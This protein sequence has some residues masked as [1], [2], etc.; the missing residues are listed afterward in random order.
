MTTAIK[1][2]KGDQVVDGRAFDLESCVVK[3]VGDGSNRYHVIASFDAE[4]RDGETIDQ[5]GWVLNYFTEHPVLVDSHDY[6]RVMNQI[7]EFKD[8]DI[9]TRSLE[10]VAE[11]YAGHG[12]QAADWAA[13]LASKGRA[14]YSVG[15]IPLDSEPRKGGGRHYTKQELLE[16]SQVIVPSS[17]Q[18]L[19]N[20]AKG[21]GLQAKLARELLSDFDFE[22]RRPKA[23]GG[24]SVPQQKWQSA[25]MG[26][27]SD[28][29][30]VDCH[31]IVAGCDDASQIQIPICSEHLRYLMASPAE[32]PGSPPDDDDVRM[33]MLTRGVQRLKA[34]R[35]ISASNMGKLH[36][37]MQA[38]KDVHDANCTDE[39]CPLDDEE[40]VN[41]ADRDKGRKAMGEGSGAAGGVMVSD[42]GTHGAFDGK[43][44]HE[45]DA[46]GHTSSADENGMHDH[47]HSHDEDGN[48]GHAHPDS[49]NFKTLRDK[50]PQSTATQNDLPDSAFA[51]VS[52]GGE[53]DASGKTVPRSLRHLPHHKAD[54]SIDLPHLK[55]WK[56]AL[57][58]VSQTDL[59]AADRATAE[60][61]LAAHAKDEGIGD[62]A[63]EADKAFTEAMAKRLDA[64][65]AAMER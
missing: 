4:D 56:N 11:Y 25:Y 19:Q 44:S 39:N 40:D 14:A 41:P 28:Y 26:D 57:A 17:R 54:G 21:M 1:I 32:P 18:A 22:Q 49:T 5:K 2:R 30:P 10:G 8:L 63:E 31:C 50:A 12:N 47:S 33:R 15:F 61:H 13:F 35:Q 55:I 29:G 16:L 62:A 51:V 64:V 3:A 45:H 24:V 20:M 38:L 6:D 65:F 37:A 7:G 53:K 36:S 60:K 52:A 48:H 59:S 34:G 58:R 42:S 23:W 9:R 27:P 43:H 46:A